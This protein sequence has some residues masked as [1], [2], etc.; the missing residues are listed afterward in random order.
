V[1]EKNVI[2]IFEGRISRE[3][4]KEPKL[5]PCRDFFGIKYIKQGKWR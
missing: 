1:Q 4:Y 2:R 5:S 3:D